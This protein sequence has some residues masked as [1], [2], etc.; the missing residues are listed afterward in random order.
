MQKERDYSLWAD[1]V[2]SPEC[3]AYALKKDKFSG[4]EIKKIRFDHG[5]TAETFSQFYQR[6]DLL[7]ELR[8]KLINPKPLYRFDEESHSVPSI[9]NP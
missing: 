7:L 9:G 4:R 5:D 6:T 2:G 8:E 1:H 3:L